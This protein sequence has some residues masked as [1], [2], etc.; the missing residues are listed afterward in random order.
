MAPL[1]TSSLPASELREFSDQ[2]FAYHARRVYYVVGEPG[3]MVIRF[4]SDTGEARPAYVTESDL[5]AEGFDSTDSI[6]R[7]L[8]QYDPNTEGLLA[9]VDVTAL[10]MLAVHIVKIRS[11][12]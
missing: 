7:L 11:V 12:S 9:Y 3:V 5:V 10:R 8:K 4:N 1:D 6:R 2:Y